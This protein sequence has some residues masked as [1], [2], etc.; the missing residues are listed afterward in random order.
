LLEEETSRPEELPLAAFAV[1]SELEWRQQQQLELPSW[2]QSFFSTK[3]ATRERP[4]HLSPGPT[5]MARA[6]STRAWHRSEGNRANTKV[7]EDG[8]GWERCRSL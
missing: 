1:A 7:Q 2:N 6:C 4:S 8:M 5:A 3:Q